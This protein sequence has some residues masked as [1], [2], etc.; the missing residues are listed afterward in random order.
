MK[1]YKNFIN[2]SS[3]FYSNKSVKI[4]E[5]YSSDV[6]HSEVQNLHR[7]EED[8][9]EGDISDRIYEF[10]E[11]EVAELPIEKISMN[12]YEIDDDK[13]EEYVEMYK[14]TKTYPPIVLG[15]YDERW[16][17]DIIDGTHRANALKNCGL[18]TIISFVGLNEKQKKVE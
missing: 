15:Y 6:I 12:D 11:Y 4:G 1:N 5:V 10:S 7:N 18:K 8:F 16:G 14:K 17:Y 2:E 13:V 3:E 9:D